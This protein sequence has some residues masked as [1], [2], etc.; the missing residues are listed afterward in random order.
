MESLLWLL[1][2]WNSAHFYSSLIYEQDFCSFFFRMTVLKD[3]WTHASCIM[4]EHQDVAGICFACAQSTGRVFRLDTIVHKCFTMTTWANQTKGRC[5]WLKRSSSF[6][7]SKLYLLPL[8]LSTAGGLVSFG[9]AAACRG[10]LS[11]RQENKANVK[12]IQSTERPAVEQTELSHAA[13]VCCSNT[14]FRQR[15]V[16]EWLSESLNIYQGS[17][18]SI[19]KYHAL[20]S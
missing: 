19:N 12:R 20:K 8:I 3:I 4:K 17:S 14:G 2:I 10:R 18:R 7:S 13:D 15:G 1:W 9:A 11:T 6:S 16:E 5:V